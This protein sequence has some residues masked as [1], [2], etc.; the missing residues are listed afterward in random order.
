M[1][2]SYISCCLYFFHTELLSL[3]YIQN[4]ATSRP[5]EFTWVF[6]ADCS[7]RESNVTLLIQICTENNKD[8]RYSHQSI[9]YIKLYFSHKI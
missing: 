5:V 3:L 6:I 7:F 4:L 1:K 9:F 2:I 8:I